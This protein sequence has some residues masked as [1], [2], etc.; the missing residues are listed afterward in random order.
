[1]FPHANS[2]FNGAIVKIH[3]NGECI[4]YSANNPYKNLD[5]IVHYD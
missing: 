2:N 5:G 4:L 1:M 3:G